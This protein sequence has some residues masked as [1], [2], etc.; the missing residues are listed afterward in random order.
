MTSFP[1]IRVDFVTPLEGFTC[2]FS[3]CDA[4]IPATR[5]DAVSHI[6]QFHW[7]TGTRP[8]LD[9]PTCKKSLLA[10]SMGRHLLEQHSQNGGAIPVVCKFCQSGHRDMTEY[11]AHFAECHKQHLNEDDVRVEKRR[12]INP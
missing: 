1:W 10:A 5:S 2:A 9:C 7:P 4:V 8:K 11:A 12:R 6:K 3:D